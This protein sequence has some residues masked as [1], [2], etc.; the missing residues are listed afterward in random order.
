ML[1]FCPNCGFQI[2]PEDLEFCPN[3]G[4]RLIAEK[5]PEPPKFYSEDGVEYKVNPYQS[6]GQYGGE[7]TNWRKIFNI[8]MIIGG[9][10][11]IFIGLGQLY[12][13][14]F[15]RATPDYTFAELHSLCGQAI[16][17]VRIY[18]FCNTVNNTFNY[19]WQTATSAII[20]GSLCV[21]INIHLERYRISQEGS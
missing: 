9:I 13:L 10:I 11:L 20:I 4:K 5:I 3:C 8:A 6:Q 17:N 2:I 21:V 18:D 14:Y 12:V 1:E 7:K 15:I 19:T 16:M